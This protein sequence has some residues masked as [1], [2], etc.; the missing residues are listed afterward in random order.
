MPRRA[1]AQPKN[2]GG[3]GRGST[4][5]RAAGRRGTVADII[6]NAHE[7]HPGVYIPTVVLK[8]KRFTLCTF[9]YRGLD[10]CGIRPGVSFS[11]GDL[12]AKH[13]MP[14]TTPTRDP[15]VKQTNGLNSGAA[16]A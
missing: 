4:L 2:L 9:G 14:N 10:S 1:G 12:R 8:K 13:H 6:N 15:P 3:N 5:S 16:R 11:P 7:Y